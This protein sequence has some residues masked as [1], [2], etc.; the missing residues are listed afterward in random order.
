VSA[1]LAVIADDPSVLERAADPGEFLM[2]AC[3]RA[4]AWLAEALANGEIDRIAEM[5]AQA[6]A[7]RV[8]TVS[9]QLGKDAQLSASEIVRR[10]ER[11]LALAVRKGQQ[12][13]HIK[14][15]TDGGWPRDL[16]GNGV[17]TKAKVGDY[18][19]HGGTR[20]DAYA[21]T[22]G[23]TDS[24]FDE[25]I[26]ESRDEG[27]LTRKRVADKLRRR[28]DRIPE[29]SDRSFPAITRRRELMRE[30]AGQAWSSRQIAQRLGVSDDLVRRTA[31]E[32]GFEIAADAVLGRD[33]RI[34]SNRVVSETVGAMEGI[35]SGL[36]LVS[37]EDLDVA[38]ASEWVASLTESTRAVNRLIRQLRELTRD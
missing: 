5:K 23:V 17:T 25:V 21:M 27:N 3:E 1:D 4:K 14:T 28:K 19:G 7:I 22:D 11:G 15:R 34:D 8:Y 16:D 24:E 38:Q 10:A 13:G 37:P 6:E 18:L 30:W 29:S 35:A 36:Q 2:L 12:A 31:R 20:S 9:K 32:Q 26:G 33:R